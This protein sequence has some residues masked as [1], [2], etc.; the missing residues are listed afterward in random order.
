MSGTSTVLQLYDSLR[1]VQAR[2][3]ANCKLFTIPLGDPTS[4]PH[5]A[6]P[7]PHLHPKHCVSTV[8]K[9]LEAAGGDGAKIDVQLGPPG[10]R[11]PTKGHTLLRRQT[12]ALSHAGT[13]RVETPVASIEELIDAIEMVGF[14]A[15]AAV[16]NGGAV[17][18]RIKI[19]GMTCNHCTSTCTKALEGVTGVDAGRVVVDL[20]SGLAVVTTDAPV[21]AQQLGA[22][23]CAYLVVSPYVL[24]VL[25][26]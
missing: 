14:D 12:H 22:P 11:F 2:Y 26:S 13:A 7:T 9:A 10:E 15:S 21:D 1:A 16:E 23:T 3:D 17:T 20:D 25:H 24:V 4:R 18:T 5:H 8:T 6:I 19:D